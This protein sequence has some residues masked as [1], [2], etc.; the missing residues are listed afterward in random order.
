MGKRYII[1]YKE[2]FE[3]GY[4]KYHLYQSGKTIDFGSDAIAFKFATKFRFKW[5]A[6]L[7]CWNLNKSAKD[8]KI[9]QVI[10]I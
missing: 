2:I 9:Y 8:F 4:V 7:L 3:T 6:D 5:V 10:E 1:K